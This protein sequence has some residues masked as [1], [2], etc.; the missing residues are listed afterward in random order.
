MTYQTSTE[1][2][3]LLN[4]LLYCEDNGGM[5][6][7]LDEGNEGLT[8]GEYVSRILDRGLDDNMVYSTGINGKEYKDILRA[9]Q[10]DAT[11]SRL[12]I[13]DV[14]I[15][16][17][18]GAGGKSAL[19]VDPLSNEAIVSFKG[20]QGAQEWADNFSG[21]STTG[22]S[23][24]VSTEIQ[25]SALGWYQDKVKNGGYS[26]I[27][28]AGHS[29]GGNKAKYI[30]IMDDSVDR[31]I[32]HDGQGFSDE[33]VEKY[34]DQIA[35]NQHK[36]SNHNTDQD[37]VNIL[38]N[39]VGETHYYEGANKSEGPGG[40]AE[41]HCTNAIFNF[42]EYGN[43]VL[44][45]TQ[46]DPGMVELDK[47]MNSYIRSIPTSDRQ[48]T[49]AM[50][51]Q[52]VNLLSDDRLSE[53]QKL[54]KLI[55]LFAGDQYKEQSADL[56]GYILEYK[57]KYPELMDEVERIMKENGMGSFVDAIR[58][59]DE[60]SNAWYFDMIVDFAASHPN[61]VIGG[62][63]FFNVDIP[64]WVKELIEEHP[65]I[66]ELIKQTIKAKQ[67]AKPDRENG[68]DIH[69]PSAWQTGTHSNTHFS[70]NPAELAKCRQMLTDQ[71][72]EMMNISAEIIR[73]I[74]PELDYTI[75]KHLKD[76]IWKCGIKIA[77]NALS[78]GR[79]QNGF[80]QIEQNYLQTEDGIVVKMNHN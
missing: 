56:L 12:V 3:L 36:I 70:I 11:L 29:K 72:K 33:F 22:C 9:V 61:F 42:D 60:I 59:V 1:Q 46:Q 25:E 73:T 52:L 20:T 30:T 2:I 21:I 28:V 75:R 44:K 50:L 39:D 80:L 38:L 40:F 16:H 51:A 45:E 6:T 7:F 48:K 41:N 10:K 13:E 15:D 65:E 23:D 27:T 71:E 5:R 55:D 49:G 74:I 24:G 69:I 32:S 66:L 79:L 31:C 14:H 63:E 47:M 4:N 26:S 62:L 17:T 76:V 53:D 67:E 8:V 54:D 77:Q 34:A 64:S 19:F 37:F 43:Y 58:K 35:L 78:L 68:H 57:K 18:A